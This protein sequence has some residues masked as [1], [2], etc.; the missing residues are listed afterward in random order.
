M[1]KNIFKKRNR[2]SE[3]F[4]E[5][6]HSQSELNLEKPKEM[7]RYEYAY[8]LAVELEKNINKIL[9]EEGKI[10]YGFKQTTEALNQTNHKIHDIEKHIYNLSNDTETII[11]GI[12]K[13]IETSQSRI[14]DSRRIVNESANQMNEVFSVFDNLVDVFNSVEEKYKEINQF[15]NAI[16]DI[17]S[18]TNLLSLNASIEAARA[19]ESGKGF[20]VVAG[21]IK[22]LSDTT[23]RSAAD[24]IRLLGDMSQILDSVRSHSNQG[25]EI[26]QNAADTMN[27]S[28]SSFDSITQAEQEVNHQIEKVKTSQSKS[29]NSIAE[30]ISSIVALSKEE[31]ENLEELIYNVESKSESYLYILNHINQIKE[32]KDKK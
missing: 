27:K 14:S 28:T 30:N 20:A 6:V 2:K 26:V 19:G 1:L 24:I 10:T 12:E 16:T 8:I 5:N 13:S 7:D 31:T 29:I 17:A 4:N 23:E 32:L 11:H 3:E 25:K 15:A 18:Q 21:E 22:S 9:K